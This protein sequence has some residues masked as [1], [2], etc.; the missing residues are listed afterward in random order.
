VRLIEM[1]KLEGMWLLVVTVSCNVHL[2]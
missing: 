1:V 2:V